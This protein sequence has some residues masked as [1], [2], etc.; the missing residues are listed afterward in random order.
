MTT[1]SFMAIDVGAKRIGVALASAEARLSRPY[2]TITGG[3][4]ALDDIRDLL[5]KEAVQALVVGLPRG[6]EG[7]ETK[8]THLVRQFANELASTISI[9]LHFQ[10]EALTSHHAENELKQRKGNYQKGDIDALA[11]TIILDDFLTEHPGLTI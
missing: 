10:D 9:P 1:G 7:Q 11:A 2:G 3:K 4:T 5:S 8:Q 6:L